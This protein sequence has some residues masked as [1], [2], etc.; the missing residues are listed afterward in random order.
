MATQT[1]PPRDE[2]IRA[3]L[4]KDESYEGVFFTC[5]KTTGIF[6]RPACT[7]RKPLPENV[8]FFPTSQD[9]L[10]APAAHQR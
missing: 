5:V 10:L 7:A 3:F 2:M 8:E 6:C 1:L 9:A 4:Q